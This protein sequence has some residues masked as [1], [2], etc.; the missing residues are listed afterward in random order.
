MSIV[1]AGL[2]RSNFSRRAA[3]DQVAL[4]HLRL[5]V[6]YIFN[7]RLPDVARVARPEDRE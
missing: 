7:K 5:I 6:L 3:A 1:P 2:D 4:Q